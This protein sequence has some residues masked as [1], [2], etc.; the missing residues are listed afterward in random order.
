M[1]LTDLAGD[2]VTARADHTRVQVPQGPAPAPVRVA[3]SVIDLCLVAVPLAL[4]AAVVHT[5]RDANGGGVVDR[6]VFGGAAVALAV[7]LLIGNTGFAQGRGGASLGKRWC[8]LVA[9]GLD[10][11]PLGVRR[12]VLHVGH[13]EVVLRVVAEADGFRPV[14]VVRTPAELRARRVA[15]LLALLV[16]LGVVL[17]ASLAI[18]SRPLTFGEIWHGVAPPYDGRLSDTDLII[19]D[20]RLPRTLLSLVVGIAL[21]LAGGLIQGHTR[22]PLADPGILGVSAGAACAVVAAISFLGVTSAAAYVWFGLAGALVASV[23]VFG[24]ASVGSRAASPISLVLGGAAVA[25]LLSAVTSALVLLDQ[26]TLDA[27]RFWIIGSVAGRELDVL[28]PLLP[29]FAVGIVLALAGAPGLNLLGLGEEVARSL[30]ASIV[31]SRVMG[32][33]AITLLAGAATAACGPIAFIGLAVPHIARAVTGPDYRWLL[34]C[35]ALL[36]AVLLATC[37]ILGRVVARP[38]ELQVGIVLAL[39]GSPFFIALVRRRKLVGL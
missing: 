3:A 10:G 26:D 9:R 31:V 35:S 5:L 23:V 7:A 39:V 33:A 34:P 19:R 6:V 16:L 29:F 13:R 8:G 27:Y 17:L 15:S 24:L 18:G 25:A 4:G 36:G 38:A 20:L 21:G 22:N 1:R 32:V 2:G 28:V 30:G 14:K 12:S 37:D 11:Q